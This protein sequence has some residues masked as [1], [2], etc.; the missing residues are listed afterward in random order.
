MNNTETVNNAMGTRI[1]RGQEEIIRPEVL[2]DY[3]PWMMAKKPTRRTANKWGKK[4]TRR[5]RDKIDRIEIWT[6]GPQP[7]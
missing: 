7:Q 3:G 6:P 4:G 1:T 5:L 2:D